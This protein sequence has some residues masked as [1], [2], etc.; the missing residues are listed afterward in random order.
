MAASTGCTSS[1]P[2]G[3]TTTMVINL[4]PGAAGH[5]QPPKMSASVLP[6]TTATV[7]SGRHISPVVSPSIQVLPVIGPHLPHPLPPGGLL[8]SQ[9]PT[10]S[11]T[12]PSPTA[13]SP[14][15]IK[16]E[17]PSVIPVVSISGGG[18]PLSPVVI[19]SD[20]GSPATGVSVDSGIAD[21]IT[22]LDSLTDLLQETPDNKQNW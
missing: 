22:D 4:N 15:N 11:P 21:M 3:K 8:F 6:A 12:P 17:V 13:P 9:K 18:S 5:Q 19:S 2:G 10:P 14:V 1:V 7:L 16:S 20:T